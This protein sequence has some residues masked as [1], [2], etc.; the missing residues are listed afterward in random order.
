M[1]N[2]HINQGK[3]FPEHC[4]EEISVFPRTVAM[5]NSKKHPNMPEL[6]MLASGDMRLKA[7]KLNF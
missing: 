6:F 3:A 4:L 5:V 1:F 7:E 2:A